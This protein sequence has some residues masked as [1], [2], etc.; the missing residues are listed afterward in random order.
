[1]LILFLVVAVLAVL[2]WVRANAQAAAIDQLTA[3]FADLTAR[4]YALEERGARSTDGAQA[5]A[6][7]PAA[8]GPVPLGTKSVPTGSD[9]SDRPAASDPGDKSAA[10]DP[11]V[12]DPHMPTPR[13]A[14]PTPPP[15][16]IATPPPVLI[17]TPPPK[18]EPAP[19]RAAPRAALSPTRD[20]LETRIGARWLLYI[21]I[22]AIIVG[23]SYFE[24]LAIDNDWINETARTIQGGIV[25]ALL[26]YVGMRFVRAGYKFYGQIVSGG[27]VA[28]LYVST[29]ATFNLY[30][31]I[32]RPVAFVLMA[33]ITALAAWLADRQRSQGL[34]LMAVG[35]GFA[36]PFL[37][38]GDADAEIALF[39]Y[40]AI[41]IAGTMFLAHRRVWPL[42]NTVSYGFTV[43]TVLGWA[44]RFYSSAKYLPTEFFFTLFCAMFLYVL[45]ETQR[46]SLPTAR[47]ARA[48]L[49]TAP[50]AYYV[51]SLAILSPH[52]AALLVYLV[53]LALVGAVA[54]LRT[55]ATAR[56]VCWIAVFVPLALW[57]DAHAGRAW[58]VGGLAAVGGIYVIN[59][60]SDLERVLRDDEPVEPAG[61]VLLH[62]NGLAAYGCAYLAIDAVNSAA[63]APV[64]AVFA[65]WH[66]GI[67]L[68]L[69]RRHR[70]V[71]LHFVALAGSLSAIAVALQYHGAAAVAG[72]AA[73]GA[74]IVWLGLRERRE[75]FRVGGLALFGFAIVR[76][77]E[78]QVAPPSVAQILLLNSTA[79]SGL[80]VV[81]LTYLLAWLHDRHPDL[82]ART[83]QVGIGLTAAKLLI[84]GVVATE[85][86]DY[87]RIHPGG[88][89]E[90]WAGLVMA[91][92]V[93][94]SVIVGLGLQRRQEWIRAIGALVVSAGALLLLSLQFSN[95]P[96]GY[97]VVLNA[98]AAAG[99]WAVALL[100]GLALLHQRRGGHLVGAASNMA[101]LITAASLFTLSLLT[102]EIDAYWAGHGAA[103]VWSTAREGLQAIVWAT[104]GSVIVSIGVN[105]R[106]AWIRVVGG[107]VLV[108]GIVRLV[109]LEFATA[110]AGYV[111][112]ANARFVASL[113]IIAALCG[114]ARLYRSLE[115]PLDA[116]LKPRTVLLFVANAL[117]LALLT[118]E[119][120][121]FWHVRDL[122]SGA[123]MSA[124][125]ESHFARELMLSITWAM[126]ATALI[127]AGIRK[128]YAPIRY[129]GIAL[130]AVT[131]VKVFGVDM[132]ELDRIYRVSSIIVL[133]VTLLATSY[134]Y[135]RFRS[136]L[137][138]TDPD[139]SRSG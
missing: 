38:P 26:V 114:L 31:L 44:A 42:L 132:A 2:V 97:V 49:W 20:S 65:L 80:F 30:H 111:V 21:G 86:V 95:A 100:Y 123:A 81:A 58:L 77:F 13:P 25:G 1:M 41:L 115:E 79:A 134:V 73:E 33:A 133:G 107:G 52:G 47:L 124:A 75:W 102:S 139:S 103:R 34:A 122:S 54:G 4:I 19:V 3:R 59:V 8:A 35:G 127:G 63:A 113:T 16:R 94:G 108:V 53:A 71:A 70:D 48:I 87:W 110:P 14:L 18:P 131:I 56:L 62:L 106:A 40:E 12:P 60:L 45:R 92:L 90:P 15:M 7:G 112:L 88:I 72:W 28:V 130:F 125:R 109:N 66:A 11:R 129:F 116:G 46:S 36:T 67:G 51:A 118:S 5:A 89:F 32:G 117:G 99:V 68:A 85:I 93:V 69:A 64:A 96:D 55:G 105:R 10:S 126:Y 83:T 29:Y 74:A 137:T 39:T 76:L 43:L 119:I 120:T 138:P 61:I 78:V 136:Q 82:P 22:V 24:K 128:R 104:I 17:A 98:R 121:A 37:L 135:N 57:L 9:P 6:A 27:G 84:L 101:V 23:I 50:V 91:A